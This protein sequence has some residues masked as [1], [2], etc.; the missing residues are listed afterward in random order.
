MSV[1]FLV[2]DSA[3]ALHAIGDHAVRLYEGVICWIGRARSMSARQCAIRASRTAHWRTM[4]LSPL[5]AVA[6]LIP[7]AAYSHSL[8][9]A[10]PLLLIWLFAPEIAWLT[11]RARPRK[12][13]Q[14]DD[15]AR[16]FLRLV[17]RRSWLF[18]ENHVRPEDN[19]LPPDN[20]QEEPVE[21]TAHRTSP[22]NIG[23]MVLSALAAW[24]FGHMG[25]GELS[26]RMREMLD[27]LDR[28]ERWCG[29]FLNWYDTGSLV[30]LE[31]RYVSTVDSGNFAVSLVTLA[32][33]CEEVCRN[34]AF[35][36]TRWQGLD[37]SLRLLGGALNAAELH[38]SMHAGILIGELLAEIESSSTEPQAWPEL[39]E[40]CKAKRTEIRYDLVALLDTSDALSAERLSDLRNWLERSE[41]HLEAMQRDMDAALPWLRRLA[42]VPPGC[43]QIA[44]RLCCAPFA[45]HVAK[46]MGR[47]RPSSRRPAK[48]KPRQGANRGS[49]RMA[50]CT[51]RRH[52]PRPGSLAAAR[53]SS[54][55]HCAARFGICRGHGFRTALRS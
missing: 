31:P 32:S 20:H 53:T 18:F 11:G 52:T 48:A 40:L 16:A 44:A 49:S 23:M 14:L 17:A 46:P 22:T 41:H 19:W 2:S 39:L 37:D 25:T 30:P 26:A 36:V 10:A 54:E 34:P 4:W 51:Y 8:P 47:D 43:G 6:L 27:T 21:A 55:S 35:D 7:L 12:V 50:G 15:E 3:V 9:A 38:G 5:A 24:R 42:D 13:Q 29:H 45:R 33:G 1:A 28:L